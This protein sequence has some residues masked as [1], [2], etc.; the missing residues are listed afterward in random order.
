[1]DHLDPKRLGFV[2]YLVLRMHQ[3]Q[4]YHLLKGSTTEIGLDSSVLSPDQHQEF[5]PIAIA[6]KPA[7]AILLPPS[8]TLVDKTHHVSCKHSCTQC[9]YVFSNY[10]LLM[11]NHL[12]NMYVQI[13]NTSLVENAIPN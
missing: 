10:V 2:I 9:K 1:M 3:F 8:V 7:P 11:F 13:N 5:Q 12:L 4:K 6:A